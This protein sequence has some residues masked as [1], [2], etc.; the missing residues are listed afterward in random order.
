MD[1][2]KYGIEK[3]TVKNILGYISSGD[4]AIPEL[5][6]PFVWTSKQITE[7]IDSLYNGLPTGFIVVWNNDNV[8][9][10]DGK[11]STGK[12]IIIDGQQRITALRSALLGEAVITEDYSTKRFIVSYNPFNEKF[13]THKPVHDK[14]TKWIKDISIFFKDQGVELFNFIEDYVEKKF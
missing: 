13:E 14:S 4:I 3:D 11:M 7:L 12:K 8:K 2:E 6:R 10:K 5:Q 9:L 1:Y